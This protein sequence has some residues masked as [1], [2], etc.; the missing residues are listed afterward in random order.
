MTNTNIIYRTEEFCSKLLETKLTDEQRELV[1]H[2]KLFMDKCYTESV[3]KKKQSVKKYHTSNKGKARNNLA[4]KRYY[5]KNKE[6]ILQKKRE[7]YKQ[8]QLEL[9]KQKELENKN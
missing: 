4:Q 8:K 6:R 7:K 2:Y 1:N 9:Q 5:E 3:A